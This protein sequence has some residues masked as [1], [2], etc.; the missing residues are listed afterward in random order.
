MLTP[1]LSTQLTTL[2]KRMRDDLTAP[3]RRAE[4]GDAFDADA[5][6]DGAGDDAARLASRDDAELDRIYR[7]LGRLE[8]GEAD[9]CIV[10]GELIAPDRLL[11]NP[12]ADTCIAD[13]RDIERGEHLANPGGTPTM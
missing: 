1:E 5:D 13:Q 7:A 12:L 6:T 8:L 10:C 3:A 9:V 2:L 11:A 4:R